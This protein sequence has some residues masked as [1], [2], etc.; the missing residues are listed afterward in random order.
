MRNTKSNQPDEGDLLR[1][2]VS[3]EVTSPCIRKHQTSKTGDASK[4]SFKPRAPRLCGPDRWSTL[5]QRCNKSNN[6][7]IWPQG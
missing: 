2:E 3:D 5:Q 1:G 7:V 6:L 4:A